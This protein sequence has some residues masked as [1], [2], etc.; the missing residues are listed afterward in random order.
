MWPKLYRPQLDEAIGRRPRA[1]PAVVHGPW[2]LVL[3]PWTLL[4]VSLCVT[5]FFNLFIF[6]PT[7][8]CGVDIFYSIARNKISEKN[9]LRLLGVEVGNDTLGLRKMI[10]LVVC[11]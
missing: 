8:G 3:G 10:F 2:S 7:L 11:C 1:P 4:A 9:L 5:Y 6:F